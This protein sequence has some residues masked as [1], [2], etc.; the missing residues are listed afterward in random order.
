MRF[1]VGDK[2][3]V[4][5]KGSY[6]FTKPG[7]IGTIKRVD[8]HTKSYHIYFTKLTCAWLPSTNDFYIYDKDLD[9]LE[10]NNEQPLTKEQAIVKKIQ[11]MQSRRKEQGYVF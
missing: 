8:D 1:K 4:N 10:E 6:G 11:Q 3:I 5:S 2:V 9:L 7:S